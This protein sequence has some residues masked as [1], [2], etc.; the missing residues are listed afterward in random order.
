MKN[1]IIAV[2]GVAALV[3]GPALA[4]DMPVKAPPA[5]APVVTWTGGYVGLGLGGM[6]SS[7]KWTTTCF[8]DQSGQSSTG[9]GDCGPPD[10]FDVIDRTGTHTFTSSGFRPSF[11]GG[12]NMQT[13]NA[14]VGFE[15]DFGFENQKSTIAGIPG[16]IILT[17]CAHDGES[18]WIRMDYDGSLRGRAGFLA[19]PNVLVYGTG[20]FAFQSFTANVNCVIPTVSPSPT[21][22]YCGDTLG[23]RQSTTPFGWT[24]GGGI[25]YKAGQFVFRGEYRYS[26]YGNTTVTFFPPTAAVAQGITAKLHLTTQ[27]AYFGISYLWG[28][29]TAP[30]VGGGGGTGY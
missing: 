23:S 27:I 4:A 6:W 15:F 21:G 9:F 17:A 11:Y 14:V 1:L 29:T 3:A 7:T 24:G 16:C 22:Y 12:W 30:A 8:S 19:A 5:P 25:E 10:D 2:A 28:P 20:G 13:G 26:D 18:T